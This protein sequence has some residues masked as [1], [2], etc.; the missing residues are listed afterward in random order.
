MVPF[1][2]LSDRFVKK[3]SG[4]RR[5]R[6][7]VSDCSAHSLRAGFGCPLST[8]FDQLTSGDQ[9]N[10]LLARGIGVAAHPDAASA[11][12]NGDPACNGEDVMQIV[13]DH[14]HREAPSTEPLGQFENP[15]RLLDTERR[16]RLVE[17]D[18]PGESNLNI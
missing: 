4:K 2:N 1:L 10:D 9:A 3:K 18:D 8:S 15:S 16:G 11:S 6:C 7:T 12:G 13:A 14:D 17:D 5:L